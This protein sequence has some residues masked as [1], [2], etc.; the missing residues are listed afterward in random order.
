[1]GLAIGQLNVRRSAFIQE[2]PDI[3]WRKFESLDAFTSWFSIGHEVEAYE[4]HLHGRVELSVEIDGETVGFGGKITVFEDAREMSFSN[5]WY[6]DNA[7]PVPTS[8]TLRLT[9]LFEGTLVELFHHGFERLGEDAAQALEG[10]ES[11]WDNQH[12][13][14]L[15][16]LTE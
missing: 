13:K 9:P 1:M 5:N 6:G 4:P 3:I 11:G 12:L 15:R 16:E 2:A 10:Y 8:I 14:K 7:W